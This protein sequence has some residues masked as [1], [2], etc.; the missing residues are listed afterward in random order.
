MNSELTAKRLELLKEAVL[1]VTRV[2]VLTGPQTSASMV[3]QLET[4]IRSLRL[5]AEIFRVRDPM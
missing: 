2:A 4:A 3:G 5:Q 1:G